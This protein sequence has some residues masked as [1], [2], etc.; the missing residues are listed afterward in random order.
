[1]KGR[2]RSAAVMAGLAVLVF[3]GVSWGVS[4][5]SEPFP[6]SEDPP[7]CVEN[8]LS[9]GDILRPGSV[10]VSVLNAGDR[11]GLAS[12]TRADLVAR[13][14]GQ[15]ELDN[16]SES[17]AEA[18]DVRS[19]Q[20]WSTQGRSAAVRLVASYLGGKVEVVDRAGQVGGK[21]AGVVVVVGDRFPGVVPGLDRVEVASSSTVC[22]P[23]SLS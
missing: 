6:Q 15:G 2:L 23:A 18:A 8:E 1:M 21:D 19:A 12:T 11:S 20:I 9:A 22:S 7:I 16:L 14:F 13:G 4:A 10:T 5:V 17:E 3:V